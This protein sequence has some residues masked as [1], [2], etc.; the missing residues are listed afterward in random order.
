MLSILQ[1]LPVFFFIGALS[2]KYF[3]FVYRRVLEVV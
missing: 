2:G 3:I 1:N